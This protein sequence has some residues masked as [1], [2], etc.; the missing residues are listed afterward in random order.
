MAAVILLRGR[1][2]TGAQLSNDLPA[3]VVAVHDGDTL[4]IMIGGKR[5]RVRLTG[6]DAPERG[7]RPWGAKAKRHLEEL[8]DRSGRTVSLELDVEKAESRSEA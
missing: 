1:E 6:I 8:L 4:S 7:Q 3:R 5:E 2:L